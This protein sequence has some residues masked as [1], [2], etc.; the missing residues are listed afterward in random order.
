MRLAVS[1]RRAYTNI[2]DA[3]AEVFLDLCRDAVRATELYQWSQKE[4]ELLS[5]AR[6]IVGV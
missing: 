5:A 4:Y 2:S 3:I 6:R 1:R